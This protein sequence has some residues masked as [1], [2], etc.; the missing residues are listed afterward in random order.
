MEF[1][2]TERFID[3]FPT[4]TIAV[5]RGEIESVLPDT[6]ERVFSLQAKA[7]EH[8]KGQ[9]LETSTLSSH[10]HVSVWREAYQKFGVKAK[11]HKP[12]HEALARRI[13]RDEGWPKINLPV[14]IYLTNQA[15]HLLPH[16]G[17][18]ITA[19]KGDLVLDLSDASEPFEPLGGGQEFTEAGEVVYRN[20]G[21]IVTRRWNYR[22][23]EATKLT[24]STKSMMLVIESPSEAISPAVIEAAA[25]DLVRRYKE[26][27]QGKFEATVLRIGRG[28]T[29]FQ[30]A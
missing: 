29:R 16:G 21:R 12:T 14:D 5:V 2:I 6:Q 26:C 20:D 23:C 27:F 9:G 8:L 17:Y 11:N 22:D 19:L 15:A 3:L 1:I 18:D 30:I 13:L 28:S 4:P 24:D 10:Q 25:D 7:E